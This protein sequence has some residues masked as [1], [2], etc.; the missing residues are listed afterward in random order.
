MFENQ[1]EE[2][3]WMCHSVLCKD[4]GHQFG[5]DVY[6]M[7]VK[8]FLDIRMHW[9]QIVEKYYRERKQGTVIKEKEESFSQNDEEEEAWKRFMKNKT[10]KLK[11]QKARSPERNSRA[12]T[13]K[14]EPS[15]LQKMTN[16][17]KEVLQNIKN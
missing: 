8:T 15:W 13:N 16:Y 12:K 1:E 6:N 3:T 2:F 17:C 7:Y 4:F 5:S 14:A 10:E 11:R 9:D